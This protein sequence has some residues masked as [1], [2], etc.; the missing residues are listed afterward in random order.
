MQWGTSTVRY[1]PQIPVSIEDNNLEQSLDRTIRWETLLLQI[2]R[3]DL[4]KDMAFIVNLNLTDW[5]WSSIAWDP[6]QSEKT[7]NCNH[8]LKFQN[9]VFWLIQ[10][11]YRQYEKSK[12]KTENLCLLAL[13]LARSALR[14][15]SSLHLVIGSGEALPTA[16]VSWVRYCFSEVDTSMW[17][18]LEILWESWRS[19][20]MLRG[21][22][23]T[24][25]K[26]YEK[27]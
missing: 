7:P 8:V 24:S 26:F 19:W 2:N 6:E 27:K 5:H 15:P 10:E 11:N 20:V 23:W 25:L 14:N 3:E 13:D 18:L 12:A 1:K 16:E 22:S 4:M 17:E 9:Y 21:C